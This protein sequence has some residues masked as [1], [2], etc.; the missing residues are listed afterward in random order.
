[1]S[2]LF[3]RFRGSTRNKSEERKEL[4]AEMVPHDL[5]EQF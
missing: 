3:L 2:A 1:M 5:N 4:I